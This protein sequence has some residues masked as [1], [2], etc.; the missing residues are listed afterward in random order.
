MLF[1]GIRSHCL[2]TA[3]SI[4]SEEEPNY[5]KIARAP[6]KQYLVE[7]TEKNDD[8]GPSQEESKYGSDKVGVLGL[9]KSDTWVFHAP[10]IDKTL[11]RNAFTYEIAN[12]ISAFEG[13]NDWTSTSLH[14]AFEN[15]VKETGKIDLQLLRVLVTGVA[16]GPH[17]FDMLALMEKEETLKRLRTAL[18]KL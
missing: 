15:L 8:T 7:F 4:H 1:N 9:P 2:I 6:Q 10:Y 3:F 18:S 16:G 12:Q 17:L 13:V 5:Q 14:D 11:M